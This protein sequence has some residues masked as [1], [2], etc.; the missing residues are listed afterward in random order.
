[1]KRRL[2]DELILYN[3]MIKSGRRFAHTADPGPTSPDS[4]LDVHACDRSGMYRIHNLDHGKAAAFERLVQVGTLIEAL[5]IWRFHT[6][7]RI[8]M[9]NSCF[10]KMHSNMPENKILG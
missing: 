3:E 4:R 6:S 1:M 8:R 9:A 7:V 10:I 5:E 2:G